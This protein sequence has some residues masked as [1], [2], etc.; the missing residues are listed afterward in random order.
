MKLP[1]YPKLIIT[2]LLRNHNMYGL[3]CF[4]DMI[5]RAYSSA[6]ANLIK[7]GLT[8]PE[9]IAFLFWGQ[10]QNSEIIL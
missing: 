6:E 4:R 10:I 3:D 5:S 9:K 1:F 8:V 7:I 2:Q